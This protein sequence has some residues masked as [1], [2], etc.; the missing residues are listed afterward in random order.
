MAL[1]GSALSKPDVNLTPDRRRTL[2]G[3][4]CR[5]L[6]RLDVVG[7]PV[8]VVPQVAITQFGAVD[9]DVANDGATLLYV[10]GGAQ[11]AARS[12]VW[13]DREGREEPTKVPPRSDIATHPIS[14]GSAMPPDRL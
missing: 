8:A 11:E 1:S 3:M 14:T 4:V 5:E 12:I 9:F 2:R 7:N 13:V 10:P 6:N